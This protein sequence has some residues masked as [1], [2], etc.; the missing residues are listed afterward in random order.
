MTGTPAEL[1][2]SEVRFQIECRLIPNLKSEFFNLK[3]QDHL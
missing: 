3:S 2:I 1:Q